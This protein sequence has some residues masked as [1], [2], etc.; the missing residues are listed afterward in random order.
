MVTDY[1]F[2]EHVEELIRAASSRALKSGAAAV[3][4]EHL[5]AEACRHEPFAARA[6][7]R[8][9]AITQTLDAEPVASISWSAD[10]RSL[11]AQAARIAGDRGRQ[12]VCL[13]HLLDALLD[14]P[15]SVKYVDDVAAARVDVQLLRGELVQPRLAGLLD[16]LP[17]SLRLR[18]LR[19]EWDRASGWAPASDLTGLVQLLKVLDQG[20]IPA[21]WLRSSGIDEP[22][23]LERIV[24][25][26]VIGTNA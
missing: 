23:I 3:A 24:A 4:S 6:M 13:L 16:D 22:A 17:V 14:D 8:E 21:D 5:L 2:D 11:L 15:S 10:V 9:G 7:A 20:G 26:D 19:S 1:P 12:K 25:D 18:V